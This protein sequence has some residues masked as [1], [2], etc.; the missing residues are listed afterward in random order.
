[1]GTHHRMM[2]H[3]AT[4]TA[5]EVFELALMGATVSQ[6]KA[7]VAIFSPILSILAYNQIKLGHEDV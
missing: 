3:Q 2:G 4:R 6:I 1:M 5:S 7:I